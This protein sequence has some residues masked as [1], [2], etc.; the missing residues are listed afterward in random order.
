MYMTVT[1][2]QQAAEGMKVKVAWLEFEYSTFPDLTVGCVL[3]EHA[4]D[5]YGFSSNQS[6]ITCQSPIHEQE[7]SIDL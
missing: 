5:A 1:L 3:A 7:Q 2:Y 4:A 6:V